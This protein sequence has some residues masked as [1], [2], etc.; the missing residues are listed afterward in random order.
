MSADSQ[1]DI[2]VL[3]DRPEDFELIVAELL[4]DGLNFIARRLDSKSDFVTAITTKKPDLILSDFSLPQ[5]NAFDALQCMSDLNIEL[6]F[7]LV[8]GT[9][10]EEVAV[11]C[12][13]KGAD[14][15]ILKSSLK[16]L[17][18]AIKN[19]IDKFKA[20]QEREAAIRDLQKREELF[21]A[22][23]ENNLD[24]ISIISADGLISYISPSIKRI[25]GYLPEE[26]VGH[27][28]ARYVYPEDATIIK[29]VIREVQSATEDGRQYNNI[30]FIR[31]DGNLVNIDSC[32]RNL[33]DNPAVSGIIFNGRDVT[34]R[35]QLEA[36]FRQAQKLECVGRLA[37]SVAHD[38]NNLLTVIRS[39]V[40]LIKSAV[41][42]DKNSIELMNQISAAA[43]RASTLSRQLLTFS[44]K[45]SVQPKPI[46]ICN[47]VRSL[48][49]L[50]RRVIEECINFE[51]STWPE[52]LIVM[53]DE[54][55]IDQLL[56]NLIVNA[57]DAV[58]PGGKIVLK[59]YFADFTAD[60]LPISAQSA[61]PGKF[62]VI[63]VSDDGCGMDD[64]TLLRIFEPFFT[65]KSPDK[66]T[67]LGLSTVFGIVQ[68][69]K[70]W[71][72]VWSKKN[73]GT[74]FKVYLPLS[75]EKVLP[76]SS[77]DGLI[78][79]QAS[80][81]V[82][83][84]VED[85]PDVRKLTSQVLKRANYKV[86]EAQ[87]PKESLDVWNR[88]KDVC[89][90]VITDMVMPGS[91]NGIEMAKKMIAENP[92][93]KVLLISGYSQDLSSQIENLPAGFKYLEKPFSVD[94][95]MATLRE[96]IDQPASK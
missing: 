49:K 89:N 75:E 65:T 13:H 9:Q 79:S 1:L 17:P 67:G 63:E 28:L 3:E 71:I 48:S 45:Q 73:Q 92:D 59:T 87:S 77:K 23:I 61:Y 6:P 54:S 46:D 8:T 4:R 7:I 41:N 88:I 47:L 10:S 40:G 35:L 39:A 69:H 90:V 76:G 37:A 70:G 78:L 60:N 52:P 95:F 44:K 86:F 84:L 29:S 51:V 80:N 53:A 42:L 32:F 50:Y 91:M 57:R 31:K 38:F 11:E 20:K 5:F 14:D 74:S 25:L 72:D 21:R 15:Y 2:L 27:E 81:E 24:I 96:L 83:L 26:L 93:L 33:I 82:V 16:R 12:I 34:E 30:R 58:S 56:M 55:M 22:L 64:Q 85:D 43:D 18:S 68:L 36:K 66:G 94:V 19:A 62:A